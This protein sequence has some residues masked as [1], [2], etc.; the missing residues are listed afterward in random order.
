MG[1]NLRFR[2]SGEVLA[3]AGP[4]DKFDAVDAVVGHDFGQLS[5][6]C[7]RPS[8]LAFVWIVSWLIAPEAFEDRSPCTY[9][10]S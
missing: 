7:R 5:V 3:D 10:K 8:E 6:L 4:V 2:T 9:N 1:E